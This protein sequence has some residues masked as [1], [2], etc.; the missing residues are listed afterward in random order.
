MD[1][2]FQLVEELKKQGYIR[3]EKIFKAFLEIRR[4]DFLHAADY[5]KE[6]LNSPIPIGYG[7]TNSQPQTVAVM[8][9]VLAPEPGQKI[10]DVG[11][12]SGWTTALLAEIAGSAGE[13]Y[14]L[15]LNPQLV[16]FAR[17]NLIK[18][19]FSESSK[20]QIIQGNGYNGLPDQAPFDRILVSAAAPY[21]PSELLRQLKPN[22]ILVMPI[23]LAMSSQQIHKITRDNNSYQ[24][25][26]YP[27][28]IFVPLINFN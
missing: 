17:R 4:K 12:G 20:I 6:Y 3:S 23:G 14:G 2:Y 21:L 1:K 18:H 9:E 13:L 26:I 11:C 8:L 15:E 5:Q 25:E 24:T 10:L 28:F 19:N 27:G 22:G 7:Q 16:Q